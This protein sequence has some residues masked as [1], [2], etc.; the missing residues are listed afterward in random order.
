MKTA[1]LTIDGMTCGGCVASVRRVLERLPGVASVAVD[2][3]SASAVVTLEQPEATEA[4]MRGA[5]VGAG[6]TVRQF[7]LS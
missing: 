6:F 4:A 2:L 5:I 3:A 7:T 1:T